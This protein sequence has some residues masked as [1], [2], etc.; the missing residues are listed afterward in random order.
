MSAA[1]E[2]QQQPVF[3]VISGSPTEEE[4][5]AITVVFAAMAGPDRS[6]GTATQPRAARYN[7]YW[8]SVRR[9]FRTGREAW[10]SGPGG[11]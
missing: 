9:S 1:A 11:F 8:R 3:R 4:L 10:K 5:A 7:A 2:E 6:P